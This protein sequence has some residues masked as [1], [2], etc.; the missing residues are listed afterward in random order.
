MRIFVYVDAFNFYHGLTKNTPYRW[1]D[2]SKLCSVLLP[3]DPINVIKVFTAYSKSFPCNPN[4][5]QRQ[6][7]Y[8]RALKTIPNLEIYTS[9]F[10]SATRYF[11]CADNLP[12]TNMV[13]VRFSKEKGSDVKLASQLLLDGFRDRYDMAVVFTNDSDMVMPIQ[14]V[15]YE[16]RK[17]IGICLTTR[18]P[19]PSRPGSK[20]LMKAANFSKLITA[21]MLAA[22]QFLD[23]FVDAN[24]KLI[25]KPE[26]W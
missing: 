21:E 9:K 8:L 6:R 18:P 17:R 5:P 1:C 12:A 3:N 7:I 16:L 11:P 24:G 4:A 19:D 2:L 15:R 23:R 13:A 26:G 14:I 25:E 20:D 22:S 10:S